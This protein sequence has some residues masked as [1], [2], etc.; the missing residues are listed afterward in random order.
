M[1]T[2]S[3]FAVDAVCPVTA[4]MWMDY[5]GNVGFGGFEPSYPLHMASGAFVSATGV[6]TNAFSREYKDQIDE[7]TL[8]DA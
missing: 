8:E 2:R 7:L 3:S 6:W 5:D 4:I 1:F